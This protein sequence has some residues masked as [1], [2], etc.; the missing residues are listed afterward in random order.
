MTYT[1]AYAL[2]YLTYATTNTNDVNNPNGRYITWLSKLNKYMLIYITSLKAYLSYAVL[3]VLI[4]N[5]L[6]NSV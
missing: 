3:C 6:D 1:T 4:T 2:I 5:V